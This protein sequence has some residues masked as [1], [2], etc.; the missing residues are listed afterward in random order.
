MVLAP[1]GGA[2]FST[3]ESQQEAGIQVAEVQEFLDRYMWLKHGKYWVGTLV[4]TF[5]VRD[6]SK[7]VPE[8]ILGH[9]STLFGPC[10]STLRPF[11]SPWD[12]PQN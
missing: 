9:I 8:R 4:D 3:P 10:G 5:Q 6:V 7:A 11:W 12:V 2:F 1:G